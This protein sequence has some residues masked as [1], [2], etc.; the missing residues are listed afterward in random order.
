MDSPIHPDLQP[1]PRSRIPVPFPIRND[2]LIQGHDIELAPR[3]FEETL[4]N[5]TPEVLPPSHPELATPDTKPPQPHP[6]ALALPDDL[7]KAWDDAKSQTYGGGGGGSRPGSAHSQSVSHFTGHGQ[8][9][10]QALGHAHAYSVATT[11][12]A[13]GGVGLGRTATAS[14]FG[15]GPGRG[16]G[17]RGR[18]SY[19]D[20]TS[21]FESDP[22]GGSVT[23][24]GGREGGWEG[25]GGVVGLGGGVPLRSA[26]AARERGV[27]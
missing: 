17:A 16:L 6:Y 5:P 20:F 19:P 3:P 23:S 25:V 14:P 2:P 26:D 10:G 21:P 15:Q 24:D 4:R 8:G 27:W 7:P 18:Y 13:L 9:H 11:A 22:V 1:N 12:P